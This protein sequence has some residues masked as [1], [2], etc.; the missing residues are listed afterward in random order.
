MAWF[1]DA[2]CMSTGHHVARFVTVMVLVDVTVRATR[3]KHTTNDGRGYGADIK[4]TEKRLIDYELW[5]WFDP[6]F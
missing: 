5:L 4:L 1:F 6:W 3:T 2:L